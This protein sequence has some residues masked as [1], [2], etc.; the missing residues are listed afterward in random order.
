M[1]AAVVYLKQSNKTSWFNAQLSTG[2]ILF[3]AP[4]TEA[5]TGFAPFRVGHKQV[6]EGSYFVDF[7]VSFQLYIWTRN[8]TEWGSCSRFLWCSP[9]QTYRPTVARYLHQIICYYWSSTHKN[10]LNTLTCTEHGWL[11]LKMF[12]SQIFFFRTGCKEGMVKNEQ[13]E[14]Y[15]IHQ[16]RKPE[17]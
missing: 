9:W 10:V 12:L 1:Y 6:Q 15:V 17:S 5:I 7:L 11:P 16:S 13:P 3:H 8:L 2:T 14:F 4:R